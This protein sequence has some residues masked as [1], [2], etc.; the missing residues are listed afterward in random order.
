MPPKEWKRIQEKFLSWQDPSPSKAARVQKRK[1]DL[2][3]QSKAIVKDWENTIEGQRIKRLQARQLREDEEEVR[4][5][6]MIA[7]VIILQPL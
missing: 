5:I 7:P 4:T 2:H 1:E 6:F 3:L